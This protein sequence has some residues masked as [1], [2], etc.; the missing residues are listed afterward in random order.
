MAELNKRTT[1]TNQKGELDNVLHFVV[2]LDDVSFTYSYVNSV[3]FQFHVI[4]LA[5]GGY[6][7]RIFYFL[8]AESYMRVYFYKS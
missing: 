1:P 8:R 4:I 3:T 2:C 6:Q 5:Q 7:K